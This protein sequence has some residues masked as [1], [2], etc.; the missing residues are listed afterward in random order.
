MGHSKEFDFIPV[1]MG[2]YWKVLAG[3]R[4]DLICIFKRS[5]RVDCVCVCVCVCV[6]VC[7][8]E[9]EVGRPVRKPLQWF[10]RELMVAWSKY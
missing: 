7:G 9:L 1:K 3:E 8:A 5:F 4:H 6:F 10:R 2:S